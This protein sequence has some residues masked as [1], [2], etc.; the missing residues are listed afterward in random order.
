MATHLTQ[1]AVLRFL[2]S[3][4]GSVRN[5]ELLQHF[6]D[7]IREHPDRDRNR[8]LFKKFVNT[9]A[10]VKQIDGVVH[11][12]LRSRFRGSGDPPAPPRRSDGSKTGNSAETRS[13]SPA[14]TPDAPR[15]R[16]GKEPQ[17]A[18]P[19]GPR[20]P[21]G[22]A[23]PAAGILQPNKTPQVS[24]A[25]QQPGG[26]RPAQAGPQRG[27]PTGTEKGVLGGLER[28]VPGPESRVLGPGGRDPAG[29]GRVTPAGPEIGA[30]LGPER[31]VPGP[32]RGVLGPE[33]GVPGPGGRAPAG[34][35]R[36]TPA[37]PDIGAA[38]GSERG[39]PGPE[40]GAPTGPERGVLAGLKRG[41]PGPESSVLGPGGRAPAGPGRLT[42]AGP[43][44]GV[45]V[46]PERGVP[47]SERGVLDP[48]RVVPGPERAFLG[49]ERGVLGPGGRAPASQGRV[50]P[51]GPEIGAPVRSEGGVP[52]LERGALA[53]PGRV[54]P[55][56][57]ERGAPVSLERN[58]PPGP[59]RGAPAGPGRKTPAGP[60]R[61][62]PGPDRVTLAGPERGALA[63]AGRGALVCP[64]RGDP[65]GSETGTPSGPSPS[66]NSSPAQQRSPSGVP[67][68]SGA[69]H[70]EPGIE[71]PIQ[72]PSKGSRGHLQQQ[73]VALQKRSPPP[74]SLL[75]EQGIR[76]NFK[77]RKS[78]KS[79]VSQD[80]DDEDEYGEEIQTRRVSKGGAWASSGV[81]R[82]APTTP[83]CSVDTLVP[84]S[85]TSSGKGPPQIYIHS[86]EGQMPSSRGPPGVWPTGPSAG[87]Q[88]EV[89]TMSSEP[90][91]TRRSVPFGADRHSA[92]A[93]HA[94]RIQMNTGP[95]G[96]DQRHR[97]SPSLSSNASLSSDTRIS[98]SDRSLHSSSRRSE[99]SSSSSED[100]LA[101]A[102]GP[103]TEL[104]RSAL[105]PENYTSRRKGP[106]AWH[107]SAGNLCDDHK[108]MDNLSVHHRSTDQLHNDD[109]FPNQQ[110]PWFFSTGD[111]CDN[112][113]EA[114]SSEGSSCSP[115][116][117]Q[118]PPTVQRTDSKLRSRMCLSLGAD[119]DQVLDM[120][121][122]GNEAARLIRLQR[123]SSS[124][125]LH[126]N[127][128]SSSL[129]S[130]PTPPR[131]GS[132][133][134]LV[135][136]EGENGGKG[137]DSKGQ[138]LFPLE[139]KEHS[140]MVKAAAGSWGDIYSLFREDPSLLNKQDFISGF[141]VLHWIAKHGDHRVLN[142]LWYGVSKTGLSFD[143]NAKSTAGQTPLHIAAIYNSKKI[144]QLLVRSFYADVRL[145][146]MAGKRPWQYLQNPTADMLELLGAQQQLQLK[147]LKQQRD[148][149]SQPQKQRHHVR[150]NFSF[151]SPKQRPL[152]YIGMTKV[153]RSTS[154]AAFLKN[155]SQ[156]FDWHKSESTA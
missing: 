3:R 40:R 97:L 139:P 26:P 74:Q 54:T 134:P 76:R 156:P 71:T 142:T 109:R 113:E 111:L 20:G 137:K 36:V 42:P 58:P 153:K 51:V 39:A 79:A 123:I 41:V 27:A 122:T 29:P 61:G 7:Y 44:I 149:A 152:T 89:R 70:K 127:L 143:I 110:M 9:V 59:E 37:G 141:T 75:P 148:D 86:T 103:G 150:H 24:M 25:P 131:S 154:L 73:K 88:L 90:T 125:S 120:D 96:P 60:V 83:P 151:A 121:P 57:P 19:A 52:G 49:P 5:A 1:D 99:C 146:D 147:Q 14:A 35:G 82:A 108:S 126:R 98:S 72:E 124:L 84:S 18:A 77:H 63:V 30:P 12:I 107:S 34:Q 136:N 80:D 135:D 129:S 31:G 11:V 114:Y 56:G 67:A 93:Q 119:L 116:L 101:R 95:A 102:D 144:I 4:G 55:V 10:S 2:Q 106:P 128:S 53:C 140:W 13:I 81:G 6:S 91:P 46:R 15:Q 21:G 78:Y 132:P 62:T 138:P 64:G 115:Q 145:R 47:G 45:P 65:T 85:V 94:D 48:E 16:A 43:E 118:R 17:K 92:P 32:D 22:E 69:R 155:R 50:T 38:V 66:Q 100:L 33:R 130:C 117:R 23:L 105:V 28:G 133:A 8:E 87:S 104:Q 68:G 112:P